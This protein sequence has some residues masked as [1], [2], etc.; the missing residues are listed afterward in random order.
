MQVGVGL[1]NAVPG[2][3]PGAL[4]EWARR[5]DDGPFSSV[6]VVDR[7][8][9]PAFDPL[10]SLA[11]AAAVTRRVKLTTM[12]LI[13]PLR[14]GAVLA[15]E[16]ATLHALSGGRLVLGVGLGARRDDYEQAGVSYRGRAARFSEHLQTLRSWW[17]DDASPSLLVGG[18]SDAAFARA[19]RFADGYVHGGGPPRAFERAAERARAAWFDA[20]RPGEPRLWGQ[21]YFALGDA[22]ERGREYMLDYYA[23]TGSFAERIAEGMLSTPQAVVSFVK[24]YADAGCDEVVLFPAVSDPEQLDRLADAVSA[25]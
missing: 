10:T 17:D 7:V 2:T 12:V 16:A 23:F 21:G 6:G 11:T 19:A 3:A 5:A 22:A 24:G 4:V 9:Y 8:R 13:A 14:R 15:H 18:S 1:P 25:L 20:E